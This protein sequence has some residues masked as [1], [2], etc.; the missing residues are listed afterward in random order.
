MKTRT[1]HDYVDHGFGFPVVL[2]R[3]QI[4]NIH[5][6]EVPL[7]DYNALANSVAAAL[8]AK[9]SRLT[10]DEICF[11]RLHLGLSLSA[12]AEFLG[13]SHAGVKRWE[14]HKDGFTNMGW[15]TEKDIRLFVLSRL[16]RL[17]LELCGFYHKWM[18]EGPPPVAT[19]EDLRI[20][21]DKP[22]DHGWGDVSP[23]QGHDKTRPQCPLKTGWACARWQLSGFHKRK[24]GRP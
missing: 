11:L 2:K 19:R 3:V 7:I 5:G 17:P 13:V 18:L 24:R 22:S 1:E 21:I 15:S 20:E 6:D 10:G 12:L 9:A 16:G 4:A 14:N 23:A 8:A